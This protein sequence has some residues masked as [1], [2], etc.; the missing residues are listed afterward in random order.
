ML[1]G[2]NFPQLR[3]LP[4][5]FGYGG[6]PQQQALYMPSP[7]GQHAEPY[8][9]VARGW[10][11]PS[12]SG[13][14]PGDHTHSVYPSL[15]PLPSRPEPEPDDDD[16]DSEYIPGPSRRA[17]KR[18]RV[19]RQD[20]EAEVVRPK[21]KK[22]LI[23]CDFCRGKYCLRLANLALGFTAI[24]VGRKLKCDG[25]H[26]ACSNCSVR[27]RQ[28]L[29]VYQ[30]HPRRR[31]P[32]KAPRGQRKKKSIAASNR[33]NFS[34]SGSR[35]SASN[36]YSGDDFDPIGA[37]LQQQQQLPPIVPYYPPFLPQGGLILPSSRM[38]EQG[39]S[40]LPPQSQDDQDRSPTRYPRRGT[41]KREDDDLHPLDDNARR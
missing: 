1:L 15:P 3:Q 9:G 30:L 24:P 31:G 19:E 23:A 13:S 14:G 38:P 34:T 37:E 40:Q 39:S 6:D 21:G 25:R 10:E 22:T 36:E 18:R 7:L 11:L 33:D 41:I 29:C 27:G 2:I 26:P 20:H 28:S 12:S 35:A 8:P 16:Q 4:P 5:D 32:G 17:P